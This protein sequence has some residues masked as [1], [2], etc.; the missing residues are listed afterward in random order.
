MFGP[1]SSYSSKDAPAHTELKS[2]AD[3][4]NAAAELVKRDLKRE[5]LEKETKHF[6]SKPDLLAAKQLKVRETRTAALFL[7]S[8]ERRGAK[9]S[10]PSSGS[11]LAR[12]RFPSTR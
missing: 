10:R 2:R 11:R 9:S 7:L 8:R 6:A 3:G 4:Q 12:F 1:R 5:L